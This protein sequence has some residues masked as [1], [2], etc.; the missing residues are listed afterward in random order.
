V[1]LGQLRSGF[2]PAYRPSHHPIEIRRTGRGDRDPSSALGARISRLKYSAL[3][4]WLLSACAQTFASTRSQARRSTEIPGAPR[5]SSSLRS[6]GRARRPSPDWC[7]QRAAAL[8]FSVFRAECRLL[9]STIYLLDQEPCGS[10]AY[11]QISR[12]RGN[13]SLGP[14]CF[15]E[16][17]SPGPIRLPLGRS[18]SQV[19]G[20]SGANTCAAGAPAAAERR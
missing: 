8:H 7:H 1:R 15:E 5:L 20:L 11:A 12:G 18:R 2:L 17:D 13:R 10:V 16:C 19:S 3:A 6:S 14:N 9:Q 4:L